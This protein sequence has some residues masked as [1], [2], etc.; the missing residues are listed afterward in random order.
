MKVK[1]IKAN[2]TIIY[3]K[4]KNKVKNKMAENIKQHIN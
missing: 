2:K 4:N 3:I 1:Y